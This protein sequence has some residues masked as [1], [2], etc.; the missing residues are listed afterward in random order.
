MIFS[1]SPANI[2]NSIYIYKSIYSFLSY[3]YFL[4]ENTFNVSLHL[5]KS[6]WIFKFFPNKLKVGMPTVF[7]CQLIKVRAKIN[8]QPRFQLILWLS[9]ICDKDDWAILINIELIEKAHLPFTSNA[10]Y[11]IKTDLVI[12]IKIIFYYFMLNKH[13]NWIGFWW[14]I[15]VFLGFYWN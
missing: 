6:L 3:Q 12:W 14:D 10:E 9:I 11:L 8:P 1:N 4:L 15:L 13:T 7:Y 2:S 5:L